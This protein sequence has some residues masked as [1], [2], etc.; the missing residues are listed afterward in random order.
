MCVNVLVHGC[1]G[2][3]RGTGSATRDFEHAE[4]EVVIH[5][6][7]WSLGG[8]FRWSRFAGSFLGSFP[9][10]NCGCGKHVLEATPLV[11][12]RQRAGIRQGRCIWSEKFSGS[13][14]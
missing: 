13:E 11:V 3:D 8:R 5:G 10:A 4:E 9:C 6:R 1:K 12:R 7:L 14:R 2:G